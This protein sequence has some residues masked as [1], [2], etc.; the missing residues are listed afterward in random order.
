MNDRL[1]SA[2]DRLTADGDRA[3][4]PSELEATL[5]SEARREVRRRKIS[6]WAFGIGSIAASIVAIVLA[7]N[8]RPWNPSVPSPLVE[9]VQDSEQPFIGLPYITQPSPYDR[10]QVVRMQVPVVAL[11]AAGLPMQGADPGARVE[12]D[13]VVGQDG[14][15]RAVRLISNTRFN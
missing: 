1:R 13:V 14:R 6:S 12:A 10:I 5:L 9:E 11:I 8:A 3:A 7:Q 2:L 15:A 4:L